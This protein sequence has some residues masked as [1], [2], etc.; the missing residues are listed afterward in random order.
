MKRWSQASEM[1]CGG[2]HAYR[3]YHANGRVNRVVGLEGL[4]SCAY[5]VRQICVISVYMPKWCCLCLYRAASAFRPPG[6][7]YIALFYVRPNISDTAGML[8]RPYGMI[9]SISFACMLIITNMA[10]IYVTNVTE[11]EISRYLGHWIAYYHSLIII[12]IIIQWRNSPLPG[13][14]HL[15]VGFLD[16]AVGLLGRVISSPQGGQA[17]PSANF[18]S[19]PIRPPEFSG[20]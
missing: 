2:T 3:R 18:W 6:A 1:L 7:T 12:I 14:G 20:N 5:L 13:Q 16:H 19:F 17:V 8:I 4:N 9:P 15:I 10:T 11:V